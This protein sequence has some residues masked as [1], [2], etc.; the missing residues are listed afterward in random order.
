MKK[1]EKKAE[2]TTKKSGK[3]KSSKNGGGFDFNSK[4]LQKEFN[5]RMKVLVQ[6]VKKDTEKAIKVLMKE[7]KQK[8]HA[9][10][11]FVRHDVLK[12]MVAQYEHVA[13][14]V[15]DVLGIE[16]GEHK[17][18]AK[19]TPAKAA[20]RR[21]ADSR[22]QT[23]T[24]SSGTTRRPAASPTQSSTGSS[25]TTRRPATTRARKTVPPMTAASQGE[26]HAA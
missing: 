15:E 16:H 14:K 7:A 3:K 22:S 19:A 4:Q 18:A 23:T 8:I 9:G 12:S 21:P 17:P 2:K 13:E 6:E 25:G 5:K 26:G 11:E 1:T 20:T 24:A 10:S